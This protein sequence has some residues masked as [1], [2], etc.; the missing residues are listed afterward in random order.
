MLQQASPS[1]NSNAELLFHSLVLKQYA[2][3][4]LTKAGVQLRRGMVK[5]VFDKH[6]V[7]Q[8]RA[9]FPCLCFGN[10]EALQCELS[11]NAASMDMVFGA[12]LRAGVVATETHA[13]SAL[14]E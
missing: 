13:E 6:L 11:E 12:C 9:R 10:T 14:L 4:K 8:V 2:V 3:K 7:L 5:E 1:L